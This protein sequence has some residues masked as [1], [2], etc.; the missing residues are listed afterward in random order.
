MHSDVRSLQPYYREGMSRLRTYEQMVEA[1]ADRGP[2]RQE[3]RR[4]VL[5]SS[6]VFAL[7][8]HRAI[9]RAR[10]EGYAAHMDPGI[11]AEELSVCRSRHRSGPRRLPAFRGE[12]AHVL[13][14]PHRYLGLSRAVAGRHRRGPVGSL[15]STPAVYREVLV[16]VLAQDYPRDRAAIIYKV[17]T[18]P[19]HAPR[20]EHTTIRRPRRADIDLQATVVPPPRGTRTESRR[21]RTPARAGSGRE[22]GMSA[23]HA[24]PAWTTARM[25]VRPLAPRRRAPIATSTPMRGSCG[26]AARHSPAITRAQLR[27]RGRCI[28]AAAFATCL[29]CV[30]AHADGRTARRQCAARRR[31]GRKKAPRSDSSCAARRTRAASPAKR[32]RAWPPGG[33][34]QLPVD[35]IYGRA[36]SSNL[37]ATRMARQTGFLLVE[38]DAGGTTASGNLFVINRPVP[39]ATTANEKEKPC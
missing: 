5:R 2:R 19:I 39:G 11:S 28:A 7:P 14:A 30:A 18:L 13:P 15:A 6:G 36:D 38:S 24:L 37:A 8:P 20:I 9:A 1:H 23:T 3:S 10:A 25:T 16:D 17:A 26:T 32:C 22:P 21:A 31:S 34:T 29:L 33:F 12:P 4:R 27:R 35:R